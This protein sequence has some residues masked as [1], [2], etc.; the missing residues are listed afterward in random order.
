MKALY[1]LILFLIAPLGLNASVS[2]GTID[3]SFKNALVCHSV[4]CV[5]PSPGIINFAPTGTTPVTI[6]DTNGVD[7]IAWGNEIGWINFDPTGAEGLTIDASTGIISGKAWSQAAGW[8]N[9]SVTGQSVS[10]NNNGEFVGYAW[11]GGPNGGWIKFDCTFSASACVKTDWRPIPARP[12][13]PT[14]PGPGGSTPGGF[15][16]GSTVPNDFGDVTDIDACPNITGSQENIPTNYAKDEGGL[17]VLNL[18]YCKNIPGTQLTV[19]NQYIL[20]GGGQCILLTEENKPIYIPEIVTGP[21]STSWTADY[22]SNLYGL[23]SNVP[24]GFVQE[25]STCVP[26][27]A[28]YCPN[29]SGNQYSIPKNMKIVSSGYCMDMTSAEIDNENI[30]TGGEKILHYGFVP[31]PILIPIN[32]PI[33]NLFT[34]EYAK[35]DLISILLTIFALILAIILLRKLFLRLK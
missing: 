3:P 27:E 13:T 8:I 20:T 29:I 31:N 11:T 6:D 34:D 24:T 33:I 2:S 4:D 9:F 10:I 16:P 28:D 21:T 19:P 26:V 12:S 23:Q 14:T 18:D 25:G 17:C 32:F 5:T 35:V 15:S 1:F 30:P 22:C 7:G